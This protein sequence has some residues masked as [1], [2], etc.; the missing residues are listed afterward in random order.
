MAT[1]YSPETLSRIAILQ[2]KC[3]EGTVTVEEMR[4]AVL[5]LRGERRTAATASETS[6]RKTAKAAIPDAD[7]L[8]N[9][10][11]GL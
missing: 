1:P 4:E 9:E 2:Q 5:L 7:S 11:E 3:A 8:L 10:L 6:R